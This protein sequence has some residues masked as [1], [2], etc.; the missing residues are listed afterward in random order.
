M[1]RWLVPKGLIVSPY[2][3]IQQCFSTIYYCV[4]YEI[5]TSEKKIIYNSPSP[6]MLYAKRRHFPVVEGCNPLV[7]VE[8]AC[9]CNENGKSA[10]A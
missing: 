7:S 1:I 2:L 4:T 5:T 6:L 3:I 8:C 10:T 9:G